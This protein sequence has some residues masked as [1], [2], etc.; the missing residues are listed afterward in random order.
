MAQTFGGYAPGYV[1][2][3]QGDK[4]ENKAA[5]QIWA[6]VSAIMFQ[7][8][9][10]LGLDTTVFT[11][12]TKEQLSL[13]GFSYVNDSDIFVCQLD[14]AV[15]LLMEKMQL[16]VKNWELAAKVTGGVIVPE[17]CWWYLIDFE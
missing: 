8:M 9:E 12:L 11:P 13:V 5:P 14:R 16:P 3:A 1:H 15:D 10:E 4:H 7:M 6:V 2:K 17:K